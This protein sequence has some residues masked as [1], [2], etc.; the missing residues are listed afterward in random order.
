MN[1]AS[2][3]LA[4]RRGVRGTHVWTLFGPAVVQLAGRDA[5]Q[6]AA[7]ARRTGDMKLRVDVITALC[8]VSAL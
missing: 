5:G 1:C 7:S 4:K 2:V 6:F 3:P 8:P